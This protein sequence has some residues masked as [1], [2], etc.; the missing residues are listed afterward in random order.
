MGPT[1]MA[2]VQFDVANKWGHAV[3][4]S[5]SA[6]EDLKNLG[7]A[8]RDIAGG[9]TDMSTGLRATYMLL[10]KIE[11]MLTEQARRNMIRP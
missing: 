8:C 2:K 1:E 3:V 10:E 4:E 5:N 11:R 6:S 9:L 7:A